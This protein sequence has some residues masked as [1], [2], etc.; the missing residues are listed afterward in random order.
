MTGCP[1]ADDSATAKPLSTVSLAIRLS[2][3]GGEHP[4]TATTVR[5]YTNFL[6]DQGRADEIPDLLSR[7]EQSTVTLSRE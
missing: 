3:L 7:V 1:E 2:A 4:D 5:H 6:R